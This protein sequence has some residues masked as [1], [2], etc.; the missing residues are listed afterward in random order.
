MNREESIRHIEAAKL[1]LLG[2]DNQPISDLYYALDMAIEALKAEPCEDAISRQAVIEFVEYIQTIKDR[3]NEE[4]SPINYGTICDIVIRGWELVE[5][6]EVQEP[7]TGHWITDAET[8]YKA[9]NERG[10]RVDEY[11]P[12]FTD[13]IA[14]SE[15]LAKYSVLDN[16]TQ[17]FKHCPNCGS[18]NE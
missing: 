16:E 15:C 6:E 9:I 5:A 8:Y 13:D 7:K 10:N 17:F 18:K 1:M 14:C 12:Y 2:N 3:H 11:T 4:G